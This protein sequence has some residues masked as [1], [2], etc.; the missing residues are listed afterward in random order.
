[1]IREAQVEIKDLPTN[2]SDYEMTRR[3]DERS[4][5]K[6]PEVVAIFYSDKSNGLYSSVQSAPSIVPSL[7][8]KFRQLFV[9]D[10]E[11]AIAEFLEC[12][13]SLVDWLIQG[14]EVLIKHFSTDAKFVLKVVKDIYGDSDT[15]LVV[16]IQ[17][18]MPVAEAM[19]KLDAFDNEWF[20]DQ[21]DIIGN[22]VIFNLAPV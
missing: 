8:S 3:V 18:H 2:A 14:R 6:H 16:Y 1:M 11:R 4:N 9:F 13:R 5:D 19:E 7:M 20:F 22:K 17:T 12:N 21:I 15:H 10:Q